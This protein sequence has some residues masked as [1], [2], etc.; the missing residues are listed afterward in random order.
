MNLIRRITRWATQFRGTRIELVYGDITTQQVDAVVNAAKKS[1]M[2]GGG[3]DGAIHKAGGV[4][5][6]EEC[7]T[8]RDFEFPD[9][10]PTGHAVAT[11]AGNMPAKWVIHTVGPVWDLRI[12]RTYRLRNCYHN[13]LRLA[14]KLGARSVAF[15]LISSGVYGWPTADAIAQALAAIRAADTSVKV[16]LVLFDEQTYRLARKVAA[17]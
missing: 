17:E 14:E 11:T 3:V 12:D 13:S 7:R 5:I 9:G 4:A 2:G 8:I 10:L 16:R 15:P 6:L 1:L